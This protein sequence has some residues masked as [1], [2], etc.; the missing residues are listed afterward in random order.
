MYKIIR[1]IG[2]SIVILSPGIYFIGNIIEYLIYHFK[3]ISI[4]RKI[5]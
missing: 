5:Y 4:D 1:D 3:K 2:I